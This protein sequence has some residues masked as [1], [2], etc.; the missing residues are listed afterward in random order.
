MMHPTYIR[1]PSVAAARDVPE[2]LCLAVLEAAAHACELA[3]LVEHPCLNASND[4]HRG[5][6]PLI[7]A[8]LLLGRL[9][10]L[11]SLIPAYLAVADDARAA[12]DAALDRIF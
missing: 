6:P 7:A 2:R 11:R 4:E 10:E 5:A 9:V 3:L 1:I 12:D 8:N